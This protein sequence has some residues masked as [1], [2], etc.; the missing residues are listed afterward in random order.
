MSK[1]KKGQPA[2]ADWDLDDAIS[3]S[4]FFDDH[5]IAKSNRRFI[6]KE[7]EAENGN[8]F[9][10]LGLS[11]GED[12]QVEDE[13]GNTITRKG[14]GMTFFALGINCASKYNLEDA[15][16]DDVKDFIREHKEQIS[17]LEPNGTKFGKFFVSGGGELWEDL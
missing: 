5:K 1:N 8:T 7:C 16:A 9:I 11:N 4:E 12:I 10:A 13:D 6:V 14:A 3:V 15:D 17:L 2:A